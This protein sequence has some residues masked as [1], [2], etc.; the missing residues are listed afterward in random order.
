[1]SSKGV[2]TVLGTT[3]DPQ[4]WNEV[5]E[6]VSPEHRFLTQH[7]YDVW[8]RSYAANE[9]GVCP[10]VYSTTVVTDDRS[11]KKDNLF[12]CVHR[13]RA[14]IEV[15]SMAGYYYPFRT[16]LCHPDVRE[17]AVDGFA[18]G[19][20]S[21]T[22][23]KVVHAGPLQV[24]DQIGQSL[25]MSFQRNKWRT[26]KVS[27]GA[28]QVVHLPS[29]LEEYRAS[30]SRNLRKNHDR[31]KRS[32]ESMGKFDISYYNN[33]STETWARVIDSCAEVEGQ[34]WL[35]ADDNGKTRV[36]GRESFWKSYV[37]D[38]EGSRRLSVWVVS[39][40]SKPIAY[41]LA[42]DSGSCRYSISGQY[43]E[44]YKKFGVG[45]IA[46]MSMFEQSLESGITLVNMGDGDS[47]YKRRWGATPDDELQS[48]YFFRPGVTGWLLYKSFR[49]LQRVRR[50]SWFRWLNR[51]I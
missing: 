3:E 13:V 4:V 50:S 9:E 8:G 29:T 11:F 51:Y 43:D 33:C 30:I 20:Q 14:G 32:L 49:V 48:L 47:E 22:K 38:A 41:S 18:N 44:H 26:C 24:A 39:L 34:S 6:V 45:I 1:M 10:V 17:I 36:Y 31:R 2:N 15:L 12:P 19:V 21:K 42:L 35:A 28:Q 16:F 7:W 5:L 40:D 46:D 25:R 23:V 27:A 37:A